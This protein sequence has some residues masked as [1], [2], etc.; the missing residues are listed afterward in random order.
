MI[1]RARPDAQTHFSL[2][3]QSPSDQKLP[4]RDNSNIS[5]ARR[6][7]ELNSR[8]DAPSP[9]GEN[10]PKSQQPKIYKTAGDG[11]GGRAGARTWDIFGG[12]EEDANTDKKRTHI[13][14]TYGNGMG[15]RR[16][17]G[18]SWQIGD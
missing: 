2:D 12:E 8:F 17:G 6:N 15:G 7:E 16:D 10:Q 4:L 9:A 3:S 5:N 13:Y 11:L 1:H 18:S 14:K